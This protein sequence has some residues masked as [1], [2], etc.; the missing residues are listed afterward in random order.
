MDRRTGGGTSWWAKCPSSLTA[1]DLDPVLG[2]AAEV[3]AQHPAE[4]LVVEVAHLFDLGLRQCAESEM[5][6]AESDPSK[7][8]QWN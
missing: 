1:T 3:N 5:K 2:Q 4:H 6:G 8:S 7:L